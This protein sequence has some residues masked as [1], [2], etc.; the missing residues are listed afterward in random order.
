MFRPELDDEVKEQVE[1]LTD[2]KFAVKESKVSFNDRLLKL[3][4]E[5]KEYRAG[6]FPE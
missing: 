6:R 4:E 5:N 3:I 2:G 1:Y